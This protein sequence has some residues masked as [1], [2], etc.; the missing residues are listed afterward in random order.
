MMLILENV[1]LE[2]IFMA[3]RKRITIEKVLKCDV[4]I[5]IILILT[6]CPLGDKALT[7]PV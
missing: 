4:F 6:H 2:Y 1:I 5:S 3:D 7:L